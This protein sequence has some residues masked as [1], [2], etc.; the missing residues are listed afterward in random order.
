MATRN[1]LFGTEDA[2]KKL[3]PFQKILLFLSISLATFLIVL[4]YSV[5]NVSL[6]YIAGDLGVS[7]DQGT[8]VITAFAVGSAVGLAMTGFLTK[9]I[10]EVKL[11][12]TSV[13]LFTLFSAIC[14]LAFS[15]EMLI[16]ARFIQGLISGP[17][18]PLSQSI[19]I[20]Y[21][22]PE[23]R[24]R[25]LSIWSTIIITAPVIGPIL[26]GYISDWYSWPWIFYINIPIGLF[27]GLSLWAIL[28]NRE[29]STERTPTD[30]GGIVLLVLG[31][32]TL[33]ILLDKGQQ[34]DWW[35]SSVI[36]ALAL[37]SLM[38]FT[39]LIIREIWHKTPLLN[40]QLFRLPSFTISIICIAI[41]YAMYF[42]AVV[43]VPLWL[44]QFMN[45]NAEWA[46]LAVCTLGIA[47][48]LFSLVTPIIINRFG[49]VNTLMIS[50]FF[51]AMGCFYS[52]YFTT[53][54]DFF[55]IALGRFIFGCGFVCY[56]APLLSLNI[57]DVSPDKLP[58][59]TGI[60]HF[61]RAMM[62]AVGTAV[63]TTIWQRRTYFHHMRLGEN[64]T[65]YNQLL[66]Q[67]STPQTLEWLNREVDVQA[68]ILAINDAFFLM[69]WLFVSLIALLIAWTFFSTKSTTSKA[70][71]TIVTD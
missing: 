30:L 29:S 60:F 70:P 56:V 20:K 21:G 24:S 7:T 3:S 57:Q 49:K 14:G 44:Q 32:S 10:G 52:A 45:Y 1:I 40:L 41:S 16:V 64:L 62:G 12:T 42:G 27:C 48:V 71:V 31:V 65:P 4:D 28:H 58:S 69:G 36:W 22:T 34:W 50:F 23:S 26:G 63:F 54:V 19:L 11:I 47:P 17:L 6:P 68:A 5:A 13:F 33:Q 43:L 61:I 66:P 9:R 8:Y 53:Q 38:S 46:G 67:T 15:L 55:H 59:A 39:Y 25:D 51:F 2:E 37:I 18:I 35:N